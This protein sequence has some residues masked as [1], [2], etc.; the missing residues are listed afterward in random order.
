M[1]AC[2]CIFVNKYVHTYT[3]ILRAVARDMLHATRVIRGFVPV[4]FSTNSQT[5]RVSPSISSLFPSSLFSFVSLFICVSPLLFHLFFSSVLC[6]CVL[7]VVLCC[8][9]SL[10][11]VV[12]CVR[13]CVCR[14]VMCLKVNSFIR[15]SEWLEE[16]GTFCSR[17]ILKLEMGTIQRFVWWTSGARDNLTWANFGKQNWRWPP[18]SSPCVHS[19]RHRVYRHMCL[20][21][22]TCCRYTRGRFERTHGFFQRVTPT[23]T[24]TTTTTTARHSPATTTTTHNRPT[25]SFIRLNTE[26]SPSSDTARI[27]R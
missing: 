2:T 27:D 23:H 20:Y 9:V 18:C 25:C 24:T 11:F 3:V 1:Y 21:M 12:L 22:W 15:K 6:C 19:K 8:W 10:C 13:V 26:K 17:C 16:S 14:C 4:L 7:C 5:F